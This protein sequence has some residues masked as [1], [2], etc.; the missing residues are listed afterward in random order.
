MAYKSH[1]IS[2]MFS[3]FIYLFIIIIACMHTAAAKIQEGDETQVLDLIWLLI[4]RYQLPEGSKDLLL[5]WLR[6]CLSAKEIENLTTNWRDGFLLSSLVNFC[7]SSLIIDHLWLDS[8]E[9][10]EN[11]DTAMQ[12]AKEHFGIPRL[13]K[14][15][16]FVCEK[17]DENSIMTYLS[18]FY[19][20][21]TSPG[22]KMLLD[23]IQDQTS[24]QSIT[25][26][27]KAWVDGKNLAHL[28]HVTSTSGFDEYDQ[29]DELGDNLEVCKLVMEIA[30]TQL[31]VEETVTAEEFCDL[32]FSPVRRMIYLL[33]FYFLNLHAKVEDLH[34]PD[35]PGP[36]WLDISLQDGS[37]KQVEASV[38]GKLTGE[39]PKERQGIKL[40]EDGKYRIL[41]EA[42]IP[43]MY[44]LNVLVGEMRIKGSPFSVDLT[45]PDPQSI[46]LTDKVLPIKTGFP[47]ILTL[48]SRKI[49][50]GNLTADC[51][52]T[53]SGEIPSL[54]EKASPNKYTISFIPTQADTCEVDIRLDGRHIKGSPFTFPL[55]DLIQPEKIKVGK[56]VKGLLGVPVVI[57]I[58][59]SGAGKDM[60]V[61]KCQGERAGE[62]EVV[63]DPPGDPTKISFTPSVEDVYK[64]S[65]HY[66]STEILDAPLKINVR[67]DPPDAKAVRLSR[68]PSGSMNIGTKI[69]VGFDATEA[70]CGNMTATCSGANC[71]DVEVTIS[72]TSDQVYELTITPMESDIYSIYVLWSDKPV[73]GSPFNLNLIPKNFPNADKCKVVGFPELSSIVLINEEVCFQVDATAAGTGYLDIVVQV[74]NEE[75]ED[76]RISMV[77]TGTRGSEITNMDMEHESD[78]ELAPI[79]E[80]DEELRGG[81]RSEEKLKPQGEDNEL[82]DGGAIVAT[83]EEK[84]ETEE[85]Y[86]KS[87][88]E[89]DPI[90]QLTIEPSEANPQIYNVTYIP[91]QG[92]NHSMSIYW[93][94]TPIPGSPTSISVYEPQLVEYNEPIAVK[95]KTVYKRKNLKVKLQKRD[96]TVVKYHVKMEKITAGNYILIFT[97]PQPDV[98]LMHIKAK[99]KAIRGSP[100]VIKYYL[101]EISDEK[102]QDVKVIFPTS[103]IYIGEPV[104]LLIS[105][106]D[107]RLMDEVTVARSRSGEELPPPKL[108]KKKTGS[109]AAV[110][111][112][113][114]AGEE[115]VD[116]RIR[117]KPIPGSPFRISVEEKEVAAAPVPKKKTSGINLDE[118]QFI[119]DTPS[120]FKL[121]FSDLGEGEL[122][123]LCKPSTHADIEIK[124]DPSEENVHWVTVTPKKAG[125]NSLILRFGGSDILGSPFTVNFLPRGNAKKC[126]LLDPGVS[127]C[128]IDPNSKEETFCISTK[129]AGKGKVTAF[130][131]SLADGTLVDVK[132]ELHSKH[133]YHCILIP[134]AGLNY[135]L[136]VRFDDVDISGSPY[137]VLLGSPAYCKAEGE[138]LVK[139]W[140]GWENVFFVDA[141]NA[142]PGGLSVSIEQ[143]EDEGKENAVKPHITKSEDFKYKV[144]CMPSVSGVYWVTVKWKDTNIP[145]SPFKVSCRH[146][147]SA[148]QLFIVEPVSITH[149]GK[150]A[151]MVVEVDEPIEEDDKLTAFV[152]DDNGEKTDGEVCRKSDHSYAFSIQP[153]QLGNFSVFVH[154][155]T[156]DIEGSPFQVTSVPPPSMS[157][158]TMKAT[159]GENGLLIMS[160]TGPDLSFRYGDL[161]ASV[162]SAVSGEVPVQLNPVSD[163]TNTVHFKPLVGGEYQFAILYDNKHVQGSPFK[164]ISTDAAQCY[165]RG[166]GLTSARVNHPNKFSVFTENA[167][168][169]E[170]K[171]TIEAELEDERDDI[172]LIPDI[173]PRDNTVYDVSYT[174]NFTGNYK[175]AV[176]WDANEIPGSPFQILCCDPARYSVFE[177]PK[178]AA[179]GTPF[180]FGVKEATM[181][182]SYETLTVFSR[183]KDHVRHQGEI[184]RGNDGNY[185]C[186]VQPPALGKYVVHVQCNGYDISGSPF[187]FRNMPAPV[188]EKVVLSGSGIK[189]GTIGEKGAF[190]IDV[191]NAGHGYVH[192][193]VQGPKSG[194][195][196]NLTD[197]KEKKKIVAEYNPTHSG[198]Y[199]ISV[200]WSGKHVPDSPFS[201]NITDEN[202]Q[203]AARDIGVTMQSVR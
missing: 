171:V 57:P 157:D 73:P 131:K 170:L 59:T 48:T 77:S 159:E 116:V 47:A 68:P 21:L 188:A 183:G 44:S 184:S 158:F 10:V 109:V 136:T 82:Q 75:I 115:E 96:G 199:Q 144:T 180:K 119:V 97:P 155:D 145:G 36:V 31:G 105:A 78:G 98:Y 23:W 20:G 142:G 152:Q 169:G 168:P 58:D 165:H 16:D 104:S 197:G 193:K 33:Q 51:M 134:T 94:D 35:E 93:S 66:G 1:A 200:L 118:Q 203:R 14:P 83:S 126:M 128:P 141:V 79:T 53:E 74:R 64:V 111:T 137:T 49:I 190:E 46:E 9:A 117:G 181:G 7:D 189:D 195:N 138:A 178:E 61:A 124:E 122:Q 25:N 18:Y 112:P 54:V 100:F 60:L 135:M 62:V 76:D 148:S 87:A 22:Q 201:V 192:L 176:F 187:K 194:F 32:S 149:L 65:I 34:V 123:A 84:S 110:F 108:E 92:G 101:P 154:W 38:K 202:P 45:L 147:L 196:V 17:P 19:N 174:P 177:P 162:E 29:I 28:V 161:S 107:K 172:L 27:D 129:G 52:G 139:L 179:L 12:L 186:T 5:G 163:V 80:E 114:D 198:K 86:L 72:E 81:S 71:G 185:L 90:P 182:P 40:M 121:Y 63:Y 3:V 4:G 120:K 133:H 70:G 143:D 11:V 41:F 150:R 102:L 13:L 151:E 164:L 173:A 191:S 125:K 166:K 106:P 132:V 67:N 175:I 42:D 30:D 160:V 88:D 167:G 140:A 2:K 50:R 24:D 37:T 6:R 127:D 99:S 15:E 146:P 43:D 56:P 55:N 95:V 39:L 85:E 103:K 69:K 89:L 26:F 91:V 113:S 130:A 153:P 8:D 156:K